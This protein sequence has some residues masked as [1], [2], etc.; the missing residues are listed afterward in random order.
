[1]ERM[2]ECSPKHSRMH[3]N[4]KIEIRQT[5]RW[6]RHEERNESRKKNSWHEK[7]PLGL[8]VQSHLIRPVTSVTLYLF[9][10]SGLFLPSVSLCYF[11]LSVLL[12]K[13][14]WQHSW[15]SSTFLIPYWMVLAHFKKRN[16]PCFGRSFTYGKLNYNNNNNIKFY[17]YTIVLLPLTTFLFAFLSPSI[18][19][20]V[21][22]I[23]LPPLSRLI[24]IRQYF[25][26]LALP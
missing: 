24:S 19:S 1:M 16:S 14:S 3:G 25:I 7:C 4:S 17:Q 10:C 20:T 22:K 13:C 23:L 18:L 15:L 8:I 21:F 26:E 6:G 2:R 5:N 12:R 11:T 9:P